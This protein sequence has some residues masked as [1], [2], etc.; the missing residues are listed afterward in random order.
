MKACRGKN[1]EK[2]A[3]KE[4]KACTEDDETSSHTM[5]NIDHFKHLFFIFQLCRVACRILIPRPGIESDLPS[6]LL[7]HTGNTRVLKHWIGCQGS[8]QI[9]FET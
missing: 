6:P 5:S 7:H 1:L 8:P 3:F 9:T 2:T 4:P